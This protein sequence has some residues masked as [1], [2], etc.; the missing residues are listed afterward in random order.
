MQA[1]L[2]RFLVVWGLVFL[3]LAS[4]A[5]APLAIQTAHAQDNSELAGPAKKIVVD[6]SDQELTA[7][8][9]DNEVFDTLVTTGRK[10]LPTPLGTFSV[11]QKLSPTTFTSPWPKTSPFYYP[12]THI[13]YAMAF[14]E[15][16]FFLHD[17]TWRSAF[18]PGTVD[19]NQGSHGCV[20]MSLDAAKWLYNWAPVGTPVVIQA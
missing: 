19:D 14:K 5:A 11:L 6:I 10:Q 20:S 12:P 18:G 13:N 2:K 17:A 4:I 1:S 8:E 3:F 15:G 16:G 7:Y 9:G